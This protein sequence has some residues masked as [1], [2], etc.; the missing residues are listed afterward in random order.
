MIEYV[1][2]TIIKLTDFEGD[3]QTL[4]KFLTYTDQGVLYEIKRLKNNPWFVTKHGTEAYTEKLHELK[5]ASKPCLLI[6][7]GGEYFTY[8]GLAETL[9]DTFGHKITKHP[10]VPLHKTLMPWDKPPVHKNRYYQDEAAEVLFAARHGSISIPTGAGKSKIALDLVKDIGLKTVIVAPSSNIFDQ[11]YDLFS[12]HFGKKLV[13]KYGDGKKETKKI[14][15]IAMAQTLTRLEPDHPDWKFFQD[16]DVIL[17]DEAHLCSVD[18]F[19][20]TALEVLKN[21]SYRFFMSATVF[22]NDGTDLLL[23]AIT[24]P[25]VYEKTANEL[26]SEGFLAKPKFC[27]LQ[28]QSNSTYYGKDVLKMIHKHL[29]SNA[30]IHKQ[31]A[32]IA[33]KM[34]ENFDHQVMI[35]LDKVEQFKYLYPYLTHKFGF[36][37]G[38]ISKPNKEIIPKE[39]HKSD[40]TELI[41]KFN[42]LNFKI[43][44]GTNCIGFGSDTREAQTIINLQAGK[45]PIKFMQLVGRGTR[46]TDRKN[47]FNFIDFDIANIPVLSQHATE[48]AQLYQSIYDNV[49]H[50]NTYGVEI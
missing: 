27:I 31:A 33:N 13:G 48:R 26:I 47:S 23:N 46:V 34:V 15:T 2:P 7:K 18:T 49:H 8:S 21:A 50:I 39:Y 24:G 29:Y 42:N 19:K 30:F 36:A 32:L 6:E 9:H 17:Y 10:Q 45:S 11:L 38:P 37:H 41:E 40:P 1:S 22:R 4:K 20:K 28:S 43:L 5:L 3:I 44:V 16:V 12:Y 25:I 14:I 35:M